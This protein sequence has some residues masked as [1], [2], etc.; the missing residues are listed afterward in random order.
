MGEREVLEYKVGE[1][2][3]K[4]C[5]FLGRDVPVGVD[6]PRKDDFTE[7]KAQQGTA[8]SVKVLRGNREHYPGMSYCTCH[9]FMQD[10]VY[11]RLY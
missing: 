7:Y 5:E 1:G 4:L 6:F 9:C 2:W 8:G 3:D 10:N 11:S